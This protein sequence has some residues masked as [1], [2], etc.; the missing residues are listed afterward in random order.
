M[1]FP[2]KLKENTRTKWCEE[3]EKKLVFI[4]KRLMSLERHGFTNNGYQTAAA[5]NFHY[6]LVIVSHLLTRA[7]R[8]KGSYVKCLGETN[9][10]KEKKWLLH[11]WTIMNEMLHRLS[12]SNNTYKWLKNINKFPDSVVSNKRN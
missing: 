8:Q 9:K 4:K 7:W 1:R 6:F 3:N 2:S 11:S 5:V 10:D 12:N